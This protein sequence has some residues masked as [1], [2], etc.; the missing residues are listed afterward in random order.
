MQKEKNQVLLSTYR[1]P[2]YHFELV[3]NPPKN[4][5]YL[6]PSFSLPI[7]TNKFQF[8]FYKDGKI[9]MH[10]YYTP[11]LYNNPY[12]IDIDHIYHPWLVLH[13]QHH[14]YCN[15]ISCYPPEEIKF[16]KSDLNLS[17]KI[18]VS[19]NCRQIL[20]WSRWCK[21]TIKSYFKDSR[22]NEKITQIYPAVKSIKIKKK[23][24]NKLGLLFVGFNFKRKGGLQLL[25]AYKKIKNSYD[26]NLTIV[27]N[28]DDKTKLLL[29]KLKIRYFPKLDKKRLYKLYE[30]SDIFI[31]PT[32]LESFG[33]VF[34]EAMNFKLPIITTNG[35]GTPAMKEI[36]TDGKNGF[37]INMKKCNNVDYYQKIPQEELI[38]KMELLIEN[39]SLRKKMG[40]NGK[41][42][43]EEGKFCI[44]KRN[45][46]LLKVYNE[47]LFK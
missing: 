24:K 46:Q 16:I 12:V 30:N 20:P 22:I 9:P 36:I 6:N 37:L 17:K 5:I 33:M 25:E 26:I 47:Y 29:N 18:F 27:S 31:L 28:V 42:E 41:K 4:V 39:D 19:K 35:C 1:H 11:V 14:D 23:S 15:G 10:A 2:G 45:K 7:S 40:Q 38:Q 3:K 44:E 13:K 8:W 21:K 34:L 32:R 43:I